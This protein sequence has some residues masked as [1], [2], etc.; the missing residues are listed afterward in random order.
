MLDAYEAQLRDNE[1]EVLPAG[2]TREGDGPLFRLFGFSDARGFVGYRD[3]GGIEGAALDELI[4]RQVEFFAQRGERFEWK[5]H[6][7]DRPPDLATRLRAAG[8]VPEEEETV[9]IATVERIAAEPR[10]PQGISLREVSERCD[11]ERIEAHERA[12]WGD[13]SHTVAV[14]GDLEGERAADP[15]A[16]AFVVAEGGETVVC[17]GWVRFQAGTDFA[18]LWGGSTLPAWRS[19]G[20]YRAVVAYRAQLAA[21]RGFRYLEVDASSESRPILER[22]GFVAVTTTTPYIWSPG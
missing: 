10:L 12:V 5:L 22:L 20:I 9:L 21:A 6:R 1:G 4:A 19:R 11:F 17:A 7:H 18:T 8:F 14:A 16:I 2:V 13:V 15:E 3:L